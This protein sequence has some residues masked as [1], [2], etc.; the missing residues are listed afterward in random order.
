MNN[1]MSKAALLALMVVTAWS[2]T[3]TVR[4]AERDLAAAKVF[5]YK[6]DVGSVVR[7]T[8][9]VNNK[10]DVPINQLEIGFDHY[11]GASE[12]T[13]ADPS[14]IGSPSGWSSRTVSLEESDYYS[15]IWDAPVAASAIRPNQTK[16]G[17]VME[18]PTHQPQFVNSHWTVSIDGSIGTASSRIE[19]IEGPAPDVDTLAPL[20]S[21]SASPSRIWPPNGKMSAVNV[22]VS[23]SDETDPNPLVRLVSITCNECAQ[24]DISGAAFGT[25][26]RQF[27]LR[28]S[29]LGKQ[30]SGR[31]YT[32]TYEAQDSSGNTATATTLVSVPHDQR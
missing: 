4:A 25:D 27:F 30:K 32:I 11:T 15:V 5:V 31:V 16:I 24:T 3:S 13:G 12:L 6:Q 17:F 19:Q 18:V 21:V 29:R 2:G 28:A 26:D 9:V 1:K 14:R 10:S 8:Y 7:Y 23:V 22:G 20:L